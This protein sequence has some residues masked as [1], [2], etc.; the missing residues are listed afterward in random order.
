[1][2]ANL[3]R[4]GKVV[5]S[6]E[7]VATEVR[8]LVAEQ[9]SLPIAE[10]REEHDLVGDLGYDSLDLVELAMELEEHFQISVP[11]SLSEQGRTV[12]QVIDGVWHRLGEGAG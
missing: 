6:R 10:I 7:Q 9:D 2:Q 5:P 8:E 12:R 3:E 4:S 11:D 1:M